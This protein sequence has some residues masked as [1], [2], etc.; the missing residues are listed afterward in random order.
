MGTV[1]LTAA[2]IAI[3]IP[4]SLWTGSL[5]TIFTRYENI[6]IKNAY[7]VNSGGYY[8]VNIE[9]VNTGSSPT[10]IDSV[11]LNGVP[12][13][14]YTPHIT[15][16][17]NLGTL[18]LI[19]KTGAS[20]SG[21][22]IIPPS[23][24]D[25]S[26]NILTDGVTLVVTLHTTGGKDYSTLV[27]LGV[28]SVDSM[29]QK[30]S[31]D[32]G[33]KQMKIING[34]ITGPQYELG[35]YSVDWDW[36]TIPDEAM[37]VI[38]ARVDW[39]KPRPDIKVILD[40]WSLHPPW[41]GPDGVNYIRTAADLNYLEAQLKSVNTNYYWGIIFIEEEHY[42]IH[43]NFNDDVNTTWFGERMLGY[44]LYLAEVPSATRDQWLDEMFLRMV[45][46]FYNYFHPMTNVGIGVP[47][48]AITPTWRAIQYYYGNPAFAFIQENY[49]FILA[50][51]YTLNLDDY[52]ANSA[53]YY[54]QLDQYFPNQKK[55]WI[56][57]RI[58]S[59]W[60]PE[61]QAAWQE[62]AIAL[63]IKSSLDRQ[64]VVMEAIQGSPPFTPQWQLILKG[65]QL[66]ESGA[67][68]YEEYVEG[69][70]LLTGQ[71]GRTYGWVNIELGEKKLSPHF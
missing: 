42:R 15:L 48:S 2:T 50:Y 21:K 55:F 8:V 67:P 1:I 43:I 17:K 9:Y 23:A 5:A 24:A 30:G 47:D 52:K 54:A 33:S 22:I 51:A 34:S 41:E 12:Y 18:P 26:G 32:Q 70:N 56:L 53:I 40:W 36:Q 13:S 19:C 69:E 4:A 20:K 35:I 25:P 14:S 7:V 60:P 61:K 59:D 44:P 37:W 16:A 3:V 38:A 45:R 6:E 66:Y 11:L 63:E 27:V 10:S 68:Y 39:P 65:R 71:I 31:D 28:V 62:E 58:W 64:M 29:T 49:D 46:G 57:T